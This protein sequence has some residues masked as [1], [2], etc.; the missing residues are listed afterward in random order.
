VLKARE[1]GILL[2][3]KLS[4]SGTKQTAISGVPELPSAWPQNGNVCIK[5]S[6]IYA[7]KQTAGLI[8]GAEALEIHSQAPATSPFRT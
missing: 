8:L 6:T 2:K 1:N 4:V 7:Q 3:A 5:I